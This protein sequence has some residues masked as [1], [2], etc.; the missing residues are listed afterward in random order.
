LTGPLGGMDA[1]SAFVVGSVYRMFSK[2]KS[3]LLRLLCEDE[4]HEELIFK[5]VAEKWDKVEKV[6]V[7]ISVSEA[8][9][10]A[11]AGRLVAEQD[12]PR[13]VYLTYSDSE[14]LEWTK[15]PALAAEKWLSARDAAF[16]KIRPLVTIEEGIEG[17]SLQARLVRTYSPRFFRE[18]VA[19]R[20]AELGVSMLSL[21]RL[22]HKFAWFGLEVNGLLTLDSYKGITGP[23]IRRYMRKPGPRSAAEVVFGPKHRGR[24]RTQ[25]DIAAILLALEEDYVRNHLSLRKTFDNA[26][27]RS[28]LMLNFSQFRH[29]ATVL[30]NRLQ[31][32]AKREG[33]VAGAKLKKSKGRDTDIALFIGSVY[34]IDGTPFNRQLVSYF[35]TEE[36]K[37]FNAGAPTV[38]LVFDRRSKRVMG[39]HVYMGNESWKEGY[40]L[41]ILCAVTSKE[42]RLRWL[43]I[44]GQNPWRDDEN[45]RPQNIYIDGGA[46][47][48][49]LGA[50][51]LDR[52]TIGF[53]EAPPR[54]PV[55]KP[56]VEGGIGAAQAEQSHLSGGSERTNNATEKDMR[57]KAKLHANDDVL[58]FE[59]ELV[60]NIIRYN[61]TIHPD[62]HTTA[63]MK[64][65]GVAPSPDNVFRL[66]L[67]LAGGAARR[68]LAPS[69]AWKRLA[70][71]KLVEVTL[72]GVRML[73]S[74]YSSLALDAYRGAV[75]KNFKIE[76]FYDPLRPRQAYWITPDGV[77]DE[78]ERHA[79]GNEA[80]EAGSGA[81][82]EQYQQHVKALA[83]LQQKERQR[84]SALSARQ[85]KIAQ[86]V[87]LQG[88]K[89]VRKAP[90]KHQDV[91]RGLDAA[92][93]L[94]TRPYDQP[95]QFLTGLQSRAGGHVTEA[96]SEAPVAASAAGDAQGG[97]GGSDARPEV[98]P[99]RLP[100]TGRGRRRAKPAAETPDL[101]AASSKH[102][103]D[104]AEPM[105]KSEELAQ[106][107]TAQLFQQFLDDEEEG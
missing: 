99:P 20:A 79:D 4:E 24:G 83:Q 30:R 96:D 16:E 51:A 71:H 34:D 94:A 49:T 60:R 43:Q 72:N 88:R 81:D 1:A 69:D 76:V 9:E 7:A 25:K 39:W 100:D 48:S 38:L 68:M 31:L 77:L 59:R 3:Q 27:V 92:Y 15:K 17:E 26:V 32:D 28:G 80:F 13:P 44:E 103:P 82:I 14:L 104:K 89:M 6:A 47:A 53:I 54:K 86:D 93:Q 62:L 2:G 75:G 65:R 57:R 21:M 78:L 74:R 35:R 95:E 61:A 87:A 107:K 102:A 52:L 18:T 56:T 70:E 23:L 41:A 37:A 45:I 90:T 55:W 40:R 19:A 42:S 11:N 98:V 84:T 12:F 64:R 33:P 5:K 50:E 85:M 8:V 10:L 105:V 101:V 91:A 36:G 66:G 29:T 22:L 46:A 73:G 63:E 97:Q 58:E 106:S 67:E